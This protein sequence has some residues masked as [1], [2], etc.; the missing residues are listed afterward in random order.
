M[1]WWWTREE[2]EDVEGRNGDKVSIDGPLVGII[3]FCTKPPFILSSVV[4]WL[5]LTL[6][7]PKN[8]PNSRVKCCCGVEEEWAGE[9]STTSSLVFKEGSLRRNLRQC[10]I[11]SECKEF[12]SFYGLGFSSWYSQ[13]LV[14]QDQ[15]ANSSSELFMAF[16]L[17]TSSLCSG[18]GTFT[19]SNNKTKGVERYT[20]YRLNRTES[21]SSFCVSPFLWLILTVYN[22]G[23]VCT[24]RGDRGGGQGG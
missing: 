6:G 10:E 23:K 12:A 1:D 3:C 8:I 24:L 15:A 2:E 18:G 20:Q 22:F 19:T 7:S 16:L 17:P 13:E 5:L 14:S 4:I 21:M 11:Y 9:K